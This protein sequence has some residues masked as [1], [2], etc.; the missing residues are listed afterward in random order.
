MRIGIIGA[1]HIGG[2]LPGG[3]LD[4]EAEALRAE[5]RTQLGV[6][7]LQRYRA[8]VLEILSQIDRGHAAAPELALE[9]VAAA[10]SVLECR[11][12]IG[13]ETVRR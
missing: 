11:A 9:G 13:Q 7:Q 10:Q 2:T 12:R 1:G 5:G 8:L 4:L 6:E 3:G